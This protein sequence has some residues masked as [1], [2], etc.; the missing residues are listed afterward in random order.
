MFK[1]YYF[2]YSTLIFGLLTVQNIAQAQDTYG[3]GTVVGNEEEAQNVTSYLQS[4]EEGI[5][6]TLINSRGSIGGI[7]GRGIGAGIGGGS[8]NRGGGGVQ[9]FHVPKDTDYL[10]LL[11]FNAGLNPRFIRKNK[12]KLLRVKDTGPPPFYSRS[13]ERY[14]ASYDFKED[15]KQG[16]PFPT[17]KPHDIV[18][19]Q[20]KGF[21]NRPFFDPLT[22][23]SFL[24][25]L[26]SLTL[27]I[28]AI[29]NAF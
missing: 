12:I 6:V 29:S 11:V 24:I 7:G 22:D 3:Y 20:Q 18:I 25:T 14:W 28:F 27:S 21:F 4:L 1:K 13:I 17:L 2:V 15:Y 16:G 23:V 26:S 10:E 19:V 8:G 9:I 5:K